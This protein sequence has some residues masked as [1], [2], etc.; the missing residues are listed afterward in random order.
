MTQLK[1]DRVVGGKNTI[2]AQFEHDLD[3]LIEENIRLECEEQ[4]LMQN[5][6]KLQKKRRDELAQGKNLYSVAEEHLIKKSNK[7]EQDQLAVI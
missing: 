7:V 5:V 3:S 4:Q 2:T 6:K 1:K